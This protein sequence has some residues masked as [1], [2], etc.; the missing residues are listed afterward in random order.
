MLVVVIAIGCMPVPV[1]H[2]VNV[3]IVRYGLVAAVRA[4]QVAVLGVRQMWQR[5]L[6]I[7]A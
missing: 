7:V 6:V 1:M 3:L 5:V 4:V 2:V